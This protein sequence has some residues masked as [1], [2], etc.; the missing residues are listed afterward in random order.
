MN[1]V[2]IMF[3]VSLLYDNDD[4]DD[5]DDDETGRKNFAL[6]VAVE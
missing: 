1:S 2:L 4:D 5:D 6:S 3:P